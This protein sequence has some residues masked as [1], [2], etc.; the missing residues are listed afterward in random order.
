LTPDFCHSSGRQYTEGFDATGTRR[1]VVCGGAWLLAG[2]KHMRWRCYLQC[3]N[4][5]AIG[6]EEKRN[7]ASFASEFSNHVRRRQEVIHDEVQQGMT[8]T[9]FA[10]RHLYFANP[11]ILISTIGLTTE[12]KLRKRKTTSITRETINKEE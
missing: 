10:C 5:D 3:K 2:S 7:R 11:R 12:L 6:D 9:Q 4:G 8:H 1:I